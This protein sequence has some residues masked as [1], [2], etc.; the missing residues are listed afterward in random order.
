MRHIAQPDRRSMRWKMMW[1]SA[2][3]ILMS[4]YFIRRMH[5]LGKWLRRNASLWQLAMFRRSS[6]TSGPCRNVTR[7]RN[8]THDLHFSNPILHY[9]PQSSPQEV[10]TRDVMWAPAPWGVRTRGVHH[11]AGENLM[12]MMVTVTS[13]VSRARSSVTTRPRPWW[14]T[15]RWRSANWSPGRTADTPPSRCPSWSQSR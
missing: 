7:Q 4:H 2:G 5:F 9:D 12:I 6:V 3:N 8:I 15:P 11:G 13:V 14:W 10:H 1:S